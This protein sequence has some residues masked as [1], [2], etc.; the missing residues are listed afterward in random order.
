MDRWMDARKHGCMD[1]L[2]DAFK[3]GQMELGNP[4][5]GRCT[6]AGGEVLTKSI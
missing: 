6:D 1:G 3:G 5:G 2:E 4:T